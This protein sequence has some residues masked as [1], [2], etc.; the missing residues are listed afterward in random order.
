MRI[1]VNVESIHRLTKPLFLKCYIGH[2][3]W[4]LKNIFVEPL[5]M[6]AYI[7]GV[8]FSRSTREAL[9]CSRNHIQSRFPITGNRVSDSF[10]FKVMHLLS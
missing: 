3:N 4:H 10:I 6:A 1:D 5:Q 2:L 9:I 7:S 8:I